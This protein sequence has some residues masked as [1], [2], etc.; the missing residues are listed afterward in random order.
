MRS[1]GCVGLTMTATTARTRTLVVCAAALLL[2]C[3]V[4]SLV[5]YCVFLENDRY[6]IFWLICFLLYEFCFIFSETVFDR[7]TGPG[8]LAQFMSKVLLKNL[9]GFLFFQ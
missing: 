2:C 8:F 1:S 7:I 5:C 4:L 3:A 6:H 9:K